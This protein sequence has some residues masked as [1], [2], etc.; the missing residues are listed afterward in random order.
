[1]RQHASLVVS[2]LVGDNELVGRLPEALGNLTL[3]EILRLDDN[4]L[5]G[6]IPDSFANLTSL[7]VLRLE[8]NQLTGGADRLCSLNLSDFVTDC[9]PQ[10]E[11]EILCGCC[12]KCCMDERC[13]SGNIK[14]PE[15]DKCE[16]AQLV[17]T[18]MTVSGSTKNLVESWDRAEAAK[19]CDGVVNLGPGT[20]TTASG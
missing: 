10:I 5:S 12:T 9:L 7:K 4:N 16:S 2:F 18:G 11:P 17:T 15:N 13:T 8:G 19:T 6:E 14:P 3:L 1:M 20:F